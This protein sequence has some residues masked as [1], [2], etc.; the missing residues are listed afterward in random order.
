MKS[1]LHRRQFLWQG[2]I[3]GACLA[4][5][6]SV[7]F[8][9]ILRSRP[10]IPYGV[11]SG[12]PRSDGAVIWSRS[13][14]PARLWVETAATEDFRNPTRIRGPEALE[15]DDFTA[16]LALDHLPEGQECFYRVWFEDLD[17][18]RAESER[19]VGRLVTA[20]EG[21]SDVT[22]LWSGD[23]AGQ[24]F[25]IDESQGG[26]AT[27]AAMREE[28]PDF[29][30]HS[31]DLIYADAP[32]ASELAVT[33][34]GVWKNL[35]T[36]AKSK[37]AETL[38][39]FRG[40]YA[41]NL[42]DQNV[43]GFNA[44]VPQIVQWDDH[45]TVNNWYPGEVLDDPRYQVQ[46]VSLLAARARRAFFD[47]TPI[48]R[49]EA[50]PDRVHRVLRYG[51]HLDVFVVDFRSFRG[52]NSANLQ[53]EMSP[54]TAFLGA[55]QLHWLQQELKESRATWKVIAADMPIGLVVPDGDAAENGANGDGPP[56]G[57]EL[58]IAALL[59]FL[60]REA[61]R[62]VVFVTADVHYAAAHRYDP[63][64]A[65]FKDFDAF[66]EFVAGPLHAGT[67]GP[68]PLDDTFGPAVLFQKVPPEGQANLPPS[69]GFQFYGK[70]TIEGA[71]GGMTVS[72]HDRSGESLYSLTLDPS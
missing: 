54:Q 2:L 5:A 68:N 72:L 21:R 24:G 23:T 55:E 22:F 42:L 51:S 35:V 16:R 37:V 46:Q 71:T 26:M 34:G 40:N 14:R 64:R 17:D 50:R 49:H 61:V 33:G 39:E 65:R 3:G 27:Y 1:S 20:P 4:A 44:A 48:R 69:A 7:G 10:R 47:Y 63:D 38:D 67:F 29:F 56:R 13:D 19:V 28:A 36:E 59:S 12:D 15:V 18:R 11:Q 60:Q 52:P 62:N 66:H 30:I 6:P 70:V 57:R 9:A 25:G 53:T 31:G 41:Y 8:P 58:E 43:R 32:L 45:E